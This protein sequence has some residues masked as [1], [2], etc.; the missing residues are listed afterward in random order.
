MLSLYRG[1]FYLDYES[2]LWLSNYQYEIQSKYIRFMRIA[3]ERY[4]SLC[5]T[6]PSAVHEETLNK[7]SLQLNYVYSR[8]IK[9]LM[10]YGN[11]REAT[12]RKNEME[13]LFSKLQIPILAVTL[14]TS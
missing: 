1:D 11:L 4:T 7:L 8:T 3:V 10:R 5:Q 9:N 6:Q 14:A 13:Q 12:K 2:E